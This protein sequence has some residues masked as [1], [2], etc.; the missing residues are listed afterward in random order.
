MAQAFAT[1]FGKEK[2]NA[3]SSGSKPSGKINP[4][5]IAAMKELNYDLSAHTSKS[6]NEIPDIIYDAVVT[7]G[8]GDACPFVKTKSRYD[9]QIPDPKEMDEDEFRKVRDM[10]KEKVLFLLNEIQVFPFST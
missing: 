9:W 3:F 2:I 4:K 1:I 6:L 8:C 10:I 5:A 7:M